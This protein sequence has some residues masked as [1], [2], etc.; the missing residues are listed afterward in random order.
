MQASQKQWN[1]SQAKQK[2]ILCKKK[3][4]EY[5]KVG[6]WGYLSR[7]YN[8]SGDGAA[9]G[10][11]Q[12]SRQPFH[13]SVCS[14]LAFEENNNQ[15]LQPRKQKKRERLDYGFFFVLHSFT[16][17]ERERTTL[18]YYRLPIW[19]SWRVVLYCSLSRTL[20]GFL[21]VAKQRPRTICIDFCCL[22][23]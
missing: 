5:N 16:H 22:A 9:L 17:R 6:F 23:Q 13:S 18:L 14:H 21:W 7:Q 19:L 4:A 10:T 15:P 2:S 1:Q 20:F 8:I 11:R 3:N 12:M